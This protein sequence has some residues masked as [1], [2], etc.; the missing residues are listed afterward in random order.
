MLS[1]DPATTEDA[2]AI[3]GFLQR[4]ATS[5]APSREAFG[6]NYPRLLEGEDSDILVARRSGIAVG[7]LLAHRSLT[8][9]AGGPILEIIELY[10]DEAHRGEGIGRALVQA[11]LD[12][13]WAAGCVEA[14]VPTRRA[15]EFYEAL[16]FQPSATD[17][18]LR[19]VGG[20]E[21]D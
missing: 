7:Y 9:F 18:K 1:I 21:S 10:V 15:E 17:L 16:G 14:V 19:L 5:Y 2:T 20:G 6:R 12:R 11:V 4:F 8:L 13:A 3:W